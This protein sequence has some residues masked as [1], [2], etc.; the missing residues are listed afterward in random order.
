MDPPDES[1]G[2]ASF[3]D[4]L[5]RG[6]QVAADGE[7]QDD[8]F[9]NDRMDDIKADF[10]S[11]APAMS[12]AMAPA[13]VATL[14][15]DDDDDDEDDTFAKFLVD[16]LKGKF[17]S[18]TSKTARM[19]ALWAKLH[20]FNE[21]EAVNPYE[22]LQKMLDDVQSM[23]E[24][25]QKIHDV[26]MVNAVIALFQVGRQKPG[27]R[28]FLAQLFT[29]QA[30][31]YNDKEERKAVDVEL[32]ILN[33]LYNEQEWEQRMDELRKQQEERTES[34]KNKG[35]AKAEKEAAKADKAKRQKTE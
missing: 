6:Q 15:N 32:G 8:G 22:V 5:V 31:Y 11:N 35:K 3:S 10:P 20:Q 27:L 1:L 2:V 29:A 18:R 4:D 24:S 21:R 17:Q 34:L 28:K 9:Q 25:D 7:I 16:E 13:P 19:K 30:S 12:P 23:P 26:Q 33:K 14:R